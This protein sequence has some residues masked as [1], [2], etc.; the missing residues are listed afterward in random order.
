[1]SLD[2]EKRACTVNGTLSCGLTHTAV[3]PL[4]LVK[5]NMQLEALAGSASGFCP[6]SLIIFTGKDKQLLRSHRVDEDD[7]HDMDFLDEDQSLELFRSYAL[8]ENDSSIE[9]EEVSQKVVNYVQGHPL[10]LKHLGRFLY[11]KTVDK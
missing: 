6:G 10:A 7:I 9:F 4:D 3:T 5:C 11:S 2:V 8:K 1:M